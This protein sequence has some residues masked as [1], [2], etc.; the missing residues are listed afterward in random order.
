M[1][2]KWSRENGAEA[3]TIGDEPPGFIAGDWIYD[4]YHGAPAKAASESHLGYHHPDVL[5][6]WAPTRSELTEGYPDSPPPGFSLV[7]RWDGYAELEKV[8]TAWELTTILVDGEAQP[9][10]KD[11]NQRL[12]AALGANDHG[13]VLQGANVLINLDTTTLEIEIGDLQM[14]AGDYWFAE[15]FSNIS[16]WSINSPQLGVGAGNPYPR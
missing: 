13:H 15:L 10:G 16:A 4:F 12:S 7:R 9:K 8:G 2:L 3:A 11:R 1:V 5:A 6:A 14:L